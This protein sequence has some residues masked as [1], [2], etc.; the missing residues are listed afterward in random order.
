LDLSSDMKDF[1]ILLEKFIDQ[2]ITK[3]ELLRLKELASHNSEFK[4]EYDQYRS[5]IQGIKNEGLSQELRD[6]M[7]TEKPDDS[8]GV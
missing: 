6:I 5:V 8:D 7:D 1:H 2:E 4:K 3:E